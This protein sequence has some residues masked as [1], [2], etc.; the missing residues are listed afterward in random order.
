MHKFLRNHTPPHLRHPKPTTH[1]TPHLNRPT[2]GTPSPCLRKPNADSK[3]SSIPTSNKNSSTSVNID[4]S[5]KAPSSESFSAAPGQAPSPPHATA[6]TQ[7]AALCPTQ[8]PPRT[9]PRAT[10]PNHN[11]HSSPPSPPPL[12]LLALDAE[13]ELRLLYNRH[14]SPRGHRHAKPRSRFIGPGE[15]ICLTTAKR[16]ALFVWRRFIDHSGQEGVNCAIFRNEGPTLS[17]DLIREA[18]AIAAFAWP[19]QR[20]YTYVCPALIRST[21]PGAC[22]KAA[23]WRKVGLTKSGLLILALNPEHPERAPGA[24]QAPPPPSCVACGGGP[25]GERLVP[26]VEPQGSPPLKNDLTPSPGSPSAF[27]LPGRPAP[28]LRSLRGAGRPPA[29]AG[30]GH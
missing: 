7:S 4:T 25:T 9:S 29:R 26:E 16:D 20:L 8:P 23:G 19:G 18:C 24:G 5:Q 10:P 17:S 27:A 15:Y 22:F 30:P 12:W 14:Y 11:S 13:D 2:K 6:L 3:S 21:N 28:A 1:T